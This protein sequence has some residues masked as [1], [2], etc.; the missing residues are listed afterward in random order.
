MKQK[1]LKLLFDSVDISGEE[2]VAI[3]EEIIM[4]ECQIS[5][6]DFDVLTKQL[7]EERLIMSKKCLTGRFFYKLTKRGEKALTTN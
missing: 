2:F 7:L 5:K 6:E 4:K 1:I 3:N